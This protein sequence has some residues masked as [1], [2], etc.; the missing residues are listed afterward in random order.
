MSAFD[1]FMC[2]IGAGTLV[3]HLLNRAYER[4]LQR[5]TELLE[6]KVGLLQ[7]RLE[8]RE[9]GDDARL[10]LNASRVEIALNFAEMRRAARDEVQT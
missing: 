7:R 2:G 3:M 5:R 9:E 6:Q 10:E 8:G 4:L 1:W